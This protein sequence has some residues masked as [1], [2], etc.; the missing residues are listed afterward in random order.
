M[1]SEIILSRKFEIDSFSEGLKNLE[2][3]DVTK[4]KEVCFKL[5][6]NKIEQ[7]FTPDEFKSLFDAIV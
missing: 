7:T 3:L 1:E 2:F 4:N 5:L 6:C